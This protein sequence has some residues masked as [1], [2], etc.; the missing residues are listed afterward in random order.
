MKVTDG[1]VFNRKQLN[2][3]TYEL[4]IALKDHIGEYKPGNFVMLSFENYLTPFLPRPFSIFDLE[5]QTLKLVFRFVG[6]GT[7]IL[8]NSK[9]PFSLKVWGVLGN[10]FPL[11]SS[12]KNIVVAG[13]LGIVPVFNLNRFMNVEHFFVGYKNAE[14]AFLLN[15]L[16]NLYNL[17][18]TTDDGSLYNKGFVT[19]LFEKYLKDVQNER[20]NVY[21]CGPEPFIKRIYEIGQDYSFCDIYA[22]FETVMACGFGVCLGCAVDT[23]NGYIKICKKGPVFN[24]KEIFG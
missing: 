23:P 24:V 3:N 17:S 2:N 18:I 9:L 6:K 15:E 7:E 5:N 14:E 12:G 21:A 4:H 22:S 20:L 8:A 19:E 10:S 13:G 16:M 1:V 11:C